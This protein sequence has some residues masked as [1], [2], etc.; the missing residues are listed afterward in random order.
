M[1][2]LGCAG[3]RRH[4]TEQATH[5]SSRT[6]LRRRTGRVPCTE[7]R[8]VRPEG[9]GDDGPVCGA[10]GVR[11][12][13]HNRHGTQPAL[14][15]H[16]RLSPVLPLTRQPRSQNRRSLFTPT[17]LQTV[18]NRIPRSQSRRSLFTPTYLQT[19]ANR[20]PSGVLGTLKVLD[21]PLSRR[22]VGPRSGSRLAPGTWHRPFRLLGRPPPGTVLTSPTRPRPGRPSSSTPYRHRP[23][24]V[25]HQNR[26]VP[27]TLLRPPP[28][29]NLR[30][31]VCHP[32]SRD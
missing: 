14:D 24:V 5:P 11:P 12:T 23:P 29:R 16:P 1:R 17:Y 6:W 25:V 26:R 18:T 13:T 27:L 7:S 8:E 20:I 22:T 15:P 19:V 2:G 3:G 4:G 10:T 9:G 28:L 30:P 21:G 31:P 32:Q